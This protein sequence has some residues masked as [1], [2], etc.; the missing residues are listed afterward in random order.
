[1]SPPFGDLRGLA[2][3]SA[4]L[5]AFSSSP[6]LLLSAGNSL[7]AGFLLPFPA[8]CGPLAASHTCVSSVAPS[9]FPFFSGQGMYPA[10][11]VPHQEG[12]QGVLAMQL[13]LFQIICDITTGTGN[14]SSEVL[15]PIPHTPTEQ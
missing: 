1:M 12:H 4:S 2:F 13:P 15:P 6:G 9:S 10:P 3:V 5:Q 8:C 7:F 11:R 14:H